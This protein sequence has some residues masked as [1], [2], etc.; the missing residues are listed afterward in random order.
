MDKREMSIN[1]FVLAGC[2][3]VVGIITFLFLSGSVR[4]IGIIVAVIALV[5][6]SIQIYSGFKNPEN[7]KL[8]SRTREKILKHQHKVK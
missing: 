1:Q 5:F 3:L 4:Y 6:L 7:D 8:R 2:L